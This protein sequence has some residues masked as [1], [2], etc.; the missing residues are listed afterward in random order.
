MRGGNDVSEINQ[1]VNLPRFGLVL[2]SVQYLLQITKRSDR[3]PAP[4]FN[5]LVQLQPP[6]GLGAWQ[7]GQ[8]WDPPA[9]QWISRLCS[10]RSWQSGCVSVTAPPAKHQ[11]CFFAGVFFFLF[12]LCY[13]YCGLNQCLI[14]LFSLGASNNISLS[15]HCFAWSFFLLFC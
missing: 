14:C 9:L 11:A 1:R 2:F 10:T 8:P 6:E 5:I 4:R 7:G 15:S 13:F 12:L 3:E